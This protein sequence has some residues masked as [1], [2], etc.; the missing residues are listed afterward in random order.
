MAMKMPILS[1]PVGDLNFILK[2]EENS[3]IIL[4]YKKS[5]EQSIDTIINAKKEFKDK[6]TKNAL[7]LV[8]SRYDINIIAINILVL[9]YSI[10]NVITNT[11]NKNIFNEGNLIAQLNLIEMLNQNS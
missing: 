1:T 8:R 5:L 2:N 9:Y 7:E 11:N 3:L 4:N 10:L 6:I